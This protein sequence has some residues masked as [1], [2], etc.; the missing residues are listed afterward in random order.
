ML[1]LHLSGLQK[2]LTGSGPGEKSAGQ[3][4]RIR[5]QPTVIPT[6]SDDVPDD[7]GT[8][9]GGARSGQQKD[10][11]DFGQLSVGMGNGLFELE[12]R[13]IAESPK[14]EI[15][16]DL[17]TEVDGH[18]L[19][20]H[21]LDLGFPFKGLFDKPDTLLQG[22]HIF[23]VGIDPNGDH[24]FVKKGKPPFYD[25]VMSQGKGIEGTGKKSTSHGRSSLT[26]NR[27][28]Y[29]KASSMAEPKSSSREIPAAFAGCGS[30]LSSV[31]PGV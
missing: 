10:G 2:R 4:D 9:I 7:G 14:D 27:V 20:G 30:R 3:H 13:G 5:H 6:V 11:L 8:D 18:S 26:K 29:R 25:I 15:G 17:P 16:P 22:E 1:L 28:F 21:H 24:Q 19:I 23:F 31:R 12:V